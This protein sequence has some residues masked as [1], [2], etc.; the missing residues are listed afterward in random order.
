V[1]SPIDP[2]LGPLA[3]NGG[4]T[5]THALLTGSPAIDAGDDSYAFGPND[6]RGAP[7]ARIR[8]GA[9]ADTT[10]KVDIGALEAVPTIEDI[11]DK[12]VIENQVLPFTFNLGDA[13]VGFDSV[14]AISRPQDQAL[15]PNA[16]LVITG[17]GSS[18]T[19]TIT[20]TAGQSGTAIIT[21]TASKT[22]NGTL[23][24]ATDT[25]NL[26][27]I[28]INHAPTIDPIANPA[29]IPEDSGEQTVN[30]TGIGT[31]GEVQNLT[32]TATSDNWR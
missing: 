2:R 30:L 32:I 1:R 26:A 31:G 6:Q 16:N 20:P 19:L 18:R 9:D 11:T 25:F 28:H 4:R 7:F 15:I 12:S 17:S 22:I 24:T 21:V 10:A 23:L 8:D 5:Q 13:A 3:N 14:V 29:A 27:V